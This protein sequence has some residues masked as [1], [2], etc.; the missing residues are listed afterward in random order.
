MPKEIYKCEKCDKEF[1]DHYD[2]VQHEIE[3]M[4]KQDIININLTKAIEYIREKYSITITE[5]YATIYLSNCNGWVSENIQFGIHGI[6]NN[7]HKIDYDDP[8]WGLDYSK[9]IFIKY[10]EDELIIPYLDITYEG[11][12]YNDMEGQWFLLGRKD[13]ISIWEL[14]RRLNGKKVKIEVIE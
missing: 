11:E 2:C 5:Y 1:T 13:G 10:V 9:E 4:N 14:C 12:I 3:C 7:G 6:L 8:Y